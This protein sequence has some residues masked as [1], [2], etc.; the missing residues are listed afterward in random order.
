M[1]VIRDARVEDARGVAAVHISSWQEA[2]RG[3]L[4]ADVLSGLSV[5]RREQDWTRILGSPSAQRAT[6]VAADGDTV[7]GFASMGPSRNGSA[8]EA[9][10][11]L[12]AFY[13]DP[14]RWRECIGSRLHSAAIQRLTALG[15]VNA[16]LW[17]L[18]GNDRA[19]AFY[20]HV[21]WARDGQTKTDRGP[22]GVDLHEQRM[23]R[24]LPSG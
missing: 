2:Y 13:V 14:G 10:G 3:L 21:G 15:F 1:I 11:E 4:P 9:A 12:Y 7:L 8:S 5:D 18:V 17:V 16:T 6:L 23:H 19:L 24:R 20:R 22:G